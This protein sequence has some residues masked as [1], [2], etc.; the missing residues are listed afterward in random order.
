M[1]STG[2]LHI[3]EGG[4]YDDGRLRIVTAQTRE[5]VEAAFAGQAQVSENQ[6]GVLGE[7]QALFG[8]A[9]QTHFV[10][11]RLQVK[12]DDTP[13]LLLVLDDQNL[14]GHAASLRAGKN[15]RNMLPLPGSLSTVI[16][17][18]CSSTIL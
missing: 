4:H 2:S 3:P 10:T 16:S 14:V 8:A 6:V 5:H 9:R 18:R 11:G 1:A 13:Q 15:T 12:T 7:L 17:P